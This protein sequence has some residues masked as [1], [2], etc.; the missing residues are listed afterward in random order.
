MHMKRLKKIMFYKH[1]LDL[2]FATI[3]VEVEPSC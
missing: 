3:N 1:V 2:N